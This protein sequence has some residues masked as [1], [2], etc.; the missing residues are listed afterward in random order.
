M[1]KIKL[2]QLSN[3]TEIAY[4]ESGYT[5]TVG[6]L[7]QLIKDGEYDGETYYTIQR[8]RWQPSAQGMIRDYIENESQEMYEDWEERANDCIDDAVI[9]N[10]QAILDEAFKGDG[11][12]AYWTHENE[13]VIDNFDSLIKTVGESKRVKKGRG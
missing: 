8:R 9:S 4:E 3:D 12:T 1:N 6:E 5:I 7:Q 2:S 13:I 11:A 10:V